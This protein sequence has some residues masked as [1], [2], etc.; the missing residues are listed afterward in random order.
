MA[1]TT[2]KHRAKKVLRHFDDL[3]DDNIF[4]NLLQKQ[5]KWTKSNVFPI[6]IQ[7]DNPSMSVII[8][9]KKHMELAQ[10]LHAACFS[11]VRS[12]FIKAI[13]ITVLNHGQD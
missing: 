4:D 5:Q 10:C 13:K 1:P 3:I 9:K 2:F 7:H 11:P 6:K 12:T 8:Y